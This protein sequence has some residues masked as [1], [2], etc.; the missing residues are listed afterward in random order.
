MKIGNI[1]ITRSNPPLIIPEMGINHNGRLDVACK[2]V[3]S[4]KKAG[5]KIIKNQTHIVDD[6]YSVEG[7]KN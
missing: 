2:I 5:A 4:A 1:K 6:E 3:L 7:K